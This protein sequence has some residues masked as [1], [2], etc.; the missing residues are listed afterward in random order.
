MRPFVVVLDPPVFDQDLGLGQGAELGDGEQLVSD[1]GV[2]RL[3]EA[4][5]Q[6]EPG[7]M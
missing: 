6:G 3:D 2:E 5:S 1:P 4:F 7:S